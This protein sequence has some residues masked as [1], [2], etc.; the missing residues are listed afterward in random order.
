MIMIIGGIII[1]LLIFISYSLVV[2]IYVLKRVYNEVDKIE[3]IVYREEKR[4][5]AK[6]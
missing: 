1:L 6:G 2:L 3:S 4:R 5:I